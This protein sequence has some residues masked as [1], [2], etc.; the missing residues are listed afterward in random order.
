M[1]V[2]QEALLWRRAEA[3]Y[4]SLLGS[5]VKRAVASFRRRPGVNPLTRIHESD[6]GAG[7]F[8]VF[9]SVLPQAGVPP[10]TGRFIH[11]REQLRSHVNY[12]VLEKLVSDQAESP[13]L[14]DALFS[15]DLGL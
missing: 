12:Y 1:K 9:T 14:R 6:V 3:H 8:A 5:M 15:I 2:D 4:G 13:S 7:A 10:S 11:I